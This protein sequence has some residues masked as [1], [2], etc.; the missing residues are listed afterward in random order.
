MQHSL[1][2]TRT[3]AEDSLECCTGVLGSSQVREKGRLKGRK[4]P[5]RCHE[6]THLRGR[7][8]EEKQM[9]ARVYCKQSYGYKQQGIRHE[10]IPLK[11][12]HDSCEEDNTDGA[13][14]TH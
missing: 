9:R 2:G 13:V 14:R 4:L 1:A 10:R 6:E 8:G 5:R 11:M 12:T 3:C 7:G